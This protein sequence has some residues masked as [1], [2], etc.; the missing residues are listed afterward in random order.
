METS[1]ALYE[2]L[3]PRFEHEAR[4]AV[5][6]GYRVRFVMQMNAREAMH[7]LELRTSPAGHPSYR[8]VCQDMHQLIAEQAGHRALADTM[9]FVDHSTY[10]LERLAA[11]RAADARRA[12]R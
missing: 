10:G 9:T 2:A 3:A 12:T 5:A 7:L 11:E 1:A 4:Y 6:L 8:R